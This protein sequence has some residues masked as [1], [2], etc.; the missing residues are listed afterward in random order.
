ME[1]E[2]KLSGYITVPAGATVGGAPIDAFQADAFRQNDLLFEKHLRAILSSP[3][4][5]NGAD[6]DV[7]IDTLTDLPAHRLVNAT[8]ILVNKAVTLDHN[9]PLIWLASESIVINATITATTNTGVGM[10]GGS[11]G[12]SADKEGFPCKNPF[13][14]EA[15]DNPIFPKA[16]VKGEPGNS[17]P[18]I[19]DKSDKSQVAKAWASRALSILPYC[20]GG[21]QGGGTDADENAGSL[22]GGV[23]VL[24][25]PKIIINEGGEIN[26]NGGIIIKDAKNATAGCGGG[27]LVVL[28]SHASSWPKDTKIEDKISVNGGENANDSKKNGGKGLTLFIKFS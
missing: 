7:V 14:E 8:S 19:T 3:L 27:G 15:G 11:G 20:K 25:A 2:I 21:A 5:P 1:S 10:F 22:G 24:C 9:V 12:G 17:F 28:I 6:G 13:T 23:I 26:A 18:N 16:G 4:I